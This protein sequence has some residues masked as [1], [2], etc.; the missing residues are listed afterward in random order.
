MSKQRMYTIVVA[1]GSSTR[2]GSNKLAETINSKS[3]LNHSIETAKEVSDGVVVVA[4]P[5][6]YKGPVVDAVV[7]GGATRSESVKQGLN[8]V[9]DDVEIIAIHDAARPLVPIEVYERG[10]D[11]IARGE[12]G[13]IP[14]ISVV[15]TIKKVDDSIIEKTIDRSK[16]RAVQTPQIFKADVIRKA[17]QTF[18]SDTDDSAL[19]E[20]LGQK[21]VVYQGSELSRKVTTPSDLKFLRSYFETSTELIYRVGSGYDIHPFGEDENKKLI[22][23]GVEFDHVGLLGHSDSDAVAHGLTDAILSAI[24]AADLGT[25]FPA[26]EE[27]NKNVSSLIF[28]E[29]AVQMAANDGYMLSNAVIIINAQKPKLAGSLDDMRKKLS[30]AM[31]E[32]MDQNSQVTITPKHGE[33]IGEIGRG[34]AIAVY[35]TANLYKASN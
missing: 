16:L 18:E 10:R 29:K 13:A 17:H 24:G 22:L 35:A 34:E 3:V 32:I 31:S 7:P 2:Y 5:Q 1:S 12:V 14:A 23:G 19:V 9:P 33:G 26:S 15:D 20:K 6:T 21:V 25:L 30:E 27:T 28:L 4:D 11:L 8:A